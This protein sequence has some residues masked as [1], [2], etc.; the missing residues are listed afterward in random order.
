FPAWLWHSYRL[1][2]MVAPVAC[3]RRG[4]AHAQKRLSRHN[5]LVF[6]SAGALR[7]YQELRVGRAMETGMG[8]KI[9]CQL[10]LKCRIGW[11]RL[12]ISEIRL[13]AAGWEGC[14]SSVGVFGVRS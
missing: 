1:H 5:S 4:E 12:A 3:E 7:D 11:G 6:Q 9:E 14:N 8:L 2:F 13:P 10:A